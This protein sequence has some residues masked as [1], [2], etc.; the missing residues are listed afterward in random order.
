[1]YFLGCSQSSAEGLSVGPALLLAVRH[2]VRHDLCV[3][4]LAPEYNCY[5]HLKLPLS[6]VEMKHLISGQYRLP[7][8]APP[9][10]Y[11]NPCSIVLGLPSAR[12][13]DSALARFPLS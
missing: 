3:S 5:L 7:R 1:M 12:G 4:R 8:I 9:G 6:S 10:V 2:G 13:Q 11:G